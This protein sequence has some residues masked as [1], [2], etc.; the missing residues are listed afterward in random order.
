MVRFFIG[1]FNGF[2]FWHR[3]LNG[4]GAADSNFFED[5]SAR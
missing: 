4:T 5:L 3:F 1:V 2:F